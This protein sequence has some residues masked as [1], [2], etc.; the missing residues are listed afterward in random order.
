MAAR[1][2]LNPH[3]DDRESF[4]ALAVVVV[5]VG[6][7]KTKSWWK[8][9]NQKSSLVHSGLA[10]SLGLPCPEWKLQQGQGRRKQ[11]WVSMQGRSV[12]EFR[13]QGVCRSTQPVV[14]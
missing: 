2:V 6:E 13:L 11:L 3:C 5:G 10:W 7:R 4:D 1:K 14:V 8:G 12:L 9:W